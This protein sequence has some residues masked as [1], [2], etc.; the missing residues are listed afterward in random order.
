MPAPSTVRHPRL[1]LVVAVLLI[2]ANLRATITGIGPL[3]AQIADDLGTTEAALGFLAAIPLIAFAVVSPLAHGLSIRFGMSSVILW[4]LIALAVGT[5]WRSLPG[6]PVS[7]WG[8]TALIG[9]SLAIAN[10]LLPAVIKRDFSDRL[11]TVMALFT[12]FLSGTGALASGVVV[13]I[14]QIAVGDGEVGWRWALVCSGALVPLAIGA[15]IASLVSRRHQGARNGPPAS[16]AEASEA[17]TRRAGMWGD[18]VA[19]QVLAY[20]GFQSMTFY[21]L[22]TWLAPLALTLGRSE[23][24]AGIDVMVLQVCAFLG[25][26]VVPLLLRGRLARW[27]PGVIPVLGI[28]GVVG[29]ITAP[30]LFVGW[31]ILC[32]LSCGAS[33]SMTLSL[34]GLRARTPAAAS[35]LSGMAQSGGYAIAAVGPVAFGGLLA[36]TGGWLTPLLLVALVLVAQLAVGLFVGRDRHA[37]TVVEPVKA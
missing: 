2:A 10:V 34:F 14:S 5:L 28:I 13:P 8:G 25:S 30:A 26:L 35:R 36:L 31:V 22:V 24:I 21:M 32:G 6:S 20:M 29:L 9:A 19:W 11:P 37:E 18:V 15:W 23:V 12:A 33:L 27:T 17:P 7:L 4:S 1:L 16:P 3:L